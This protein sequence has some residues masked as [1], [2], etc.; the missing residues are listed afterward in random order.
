MTQPKNW[1]QNRLLLALPSSNLK[2]L[3]TELK[4][5]PCQHGQIL[6]DADS[7]LDNRTM[8]AGMQSPESSFCRQLTFGRGFV[9]RRG[10]EGLRAGQT[11]Q[12]F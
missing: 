9:F 4:Q 1:P 3:M 6:M 7:S 8:V 12:A 10:I 11:L 2:R 5:V